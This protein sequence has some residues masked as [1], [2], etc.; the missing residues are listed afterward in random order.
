[1]IQS[2]QQKTGVGIKPIT[3]TDSVYER[4]RAVDLTTANRWN[5]RVSQAKLVPS[6]ISV[7]S[8]SL[9]SFQPNS[10]SFLRFVCSIFRCF[11]GHVS[12]RGDAGL[13]RGLHRRE[14]LYQN[15]HSGNLR[16]SDH[17]GA[18]PRGQARVRSLQIAG[19]GLGFHHQWIALREQE[20]DAR[21][22][23]SRLRRAGKRGAAPRCD[24]A[25]R[26]CSE[27]S[28]RRVRVHC[29]GEPVDQD[30]AAECGG[31]GEGGGEERAGVDGAWYRREA[32][33]LRDEGRY[34]AF[35]EQDAGE[36][37]GSGVCL[38]RV[39]F[40]SVCWDWLAAALCH[41]TAGSVISSVCN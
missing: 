20:Q 24:E 9:P 37:T 10:R 13:R 4:R 30:S 2:N 21:E 8:L 11:E 5:H 29:G 41:A 14:P 6:L 12:D 22:G 31:A 7:S 35:S 1:M 32:L 16:R 19:R 40:Y 15:R 36:R 18:P 39:V 17:R 33:L 26:Q 3:G 25:H 34:A 23:D 28:R 27:S 38:E